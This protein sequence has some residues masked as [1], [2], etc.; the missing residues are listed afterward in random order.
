MS[1][2]C[3]AFLT[4]NWDN[5][6]CCTVCRLLSGRL[7]PSLCTGREETVLVQDYERDLL[8]TIVSGGNLRTGNIITWKIFLCVPCIRFGRNFNLRH[9]V[10][11]STLMGTRTRPLILDQSCKRHISRENPKLGGRVHDVSPAF[12]AGLFVL[13]MLSKSRPTYSTS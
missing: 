4:V 11:L 2:R 5:Y 12:T 8:Y 6:V 9:T 7:L 10:N 13:C 3:C 1:F